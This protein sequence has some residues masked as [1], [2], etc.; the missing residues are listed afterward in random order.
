MKQS[1]KKAA[2]E[3]ET[4][5]ILWDQVFESTC[6]DESVVHTIQDVARQGYEHMGRG[7]VLARV[8]VQTTSNG[9]GKGGGKLQLGA[10]NGVRKV[11]NTNVERTEI[12][13][14]PA[15]IF[16]SSHAQDASQ[17]TRKAPAIPVPTEK[18]V[19]AL[20][21]AAGDKSTIVDLIGAPSPHQVAAQTVVDLNVSDQMGGPYQPDQGELVLFLAMNFQG[22]NIVGADVVV[23]SAPGTLKTKMD[24]GF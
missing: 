16:H 5:M 19:N 1:D 23:E 17:A 6:E 10:E 18:E 8:H 3:F 2:Q 22:L 14:M 24:L 15:A 20:L 4:M 11:T 9:F 21:R 12:K 7:C 13:Y